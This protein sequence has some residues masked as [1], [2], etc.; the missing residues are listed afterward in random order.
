MSPD[1]HWSGAQAVPTGPGDCR[2]PALTVAGEVLHAVWT[3]DRTLYHAHLSG[4]N[5]SNPVRVAVGSQA[6]LATAPGGTVH[7]LFSARMFGND[8]IYHTT[9][10]GIKWALPEVVSRTSGVS[11]HPALA[12]GGD[13][14]LHAAWADTT[15]GYSTTYYGRREEVAWTSGPIPNG[16]GSHPA[17]RD[18]SCGRDLR[19]LA[20][21]AARHGTVRGFLCDSRI[22]SLVLALG[23]VGQ[24][25]VPFD[26]PQPGD[27]RAR[28]LPP[29]LAGGS[30]R[31]FRHSTRGPLPQRLVR[32]K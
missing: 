32:G 15:P 5:W 2:E 29:G 13:G 17:S 30:R 22:W 10:D 1:S 19:G 6:A 8:E 7:C 23:C 14:S 24:Q 25:P 12:I 21:P 16:S 3:E 11:L 26:L 20:E 27:Q 28:D 31:D 18:R 4:R 9:W